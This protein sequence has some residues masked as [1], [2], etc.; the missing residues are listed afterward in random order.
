[1]EPLKFYGFPWVMTLE[2]NQ[3]PWWDL[4]LEMLWASFNVSLQCIIQ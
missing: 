1:M 2:V 3:E 4:E